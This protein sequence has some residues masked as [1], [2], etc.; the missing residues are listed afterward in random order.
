M[1]SLYADDARRDFD[2]LFAA[3][4]A[5]YRETPFWAWNSALEPAELLRQIDIFRKMGM[6]GFHM[7][8]R[9]GLETPYLSEEFMARV[10]ECVEGA[11]ER[12]MLAWLY[13]EDRWPSGAAGGIVTKDPRYRARFLRLTPT[14]RSGE[15]PH[16]V[17]AVKLDAADCLESSRILAADETLKDGETRFFLYRELQEESSWFNGETYLDT[18]NPEAVQKFIDVTYEAYFRSVGDEFGKVIPAIFTDEPQFPA[19]TWLRS[20]RSGEDVILPWTDTFDESYRRCYGTEF[21]PTIPE[22]VWQL[23]GD[24]YST[25]RYRYH[26]HLAERFAGAFCDEIGQWCEAHGIRFSGHLNAEGALTSQTFCIGEAM[27]CYRSFQLPGID[28][29]C[30]WFEYSTA[31]Q[32]ASVSR[33]A[34]RG[35]VL[36]ELDGVTDWDF[37]FMGH[38][39]H[40]DWQAALGVTV[41][42]PHL[43]W[44]SMAGEA[45]RDYPASI[46]YQSPWFEKYHLIADHF[47]RVNCAMSRG[48]ARVRVGVIHPIESFWLHC[49]PIEQTAG[50]RQQSEEDFQNLIQWL[51]FGLIDFDFI[52][53][54][55]LP[56][57][58]PLQIGKCLIVGEMAYDVV[59][60]PP[61]VTL[62][63]S[64]LERLEQFVAAG[65]RV[66]FSGPV[67]TLADAIESD[68]AAK[69]AEK[70]EKVPFNRIDLLEALAPER[71]VAVICEDG[72]PSSTLIYQLRRENDKGYLFLVNTARMGVSFRGTVRIRGSWQS[73]LLNT[74]DGTSTPLAGRIENDWTLL[75]KQDFCAHGHLLLKL[76]PAQVCE[77]VTLRQV[78]F[79]ED[80]VEKATRGFLRMPEGTVPVSLD[81]PNVLLL[82]Q[83]EWKLSGDGTWRPRE[84][85]LRLNNLARAEMGL[86]P[87]TGHIVQPWVTKASDKI[88]DTLEMRF[89]IDSRVPVSGAR[90]ALEQPETTVVFWDGVEVPMNVESWWTDR[91]VKCVALPEFPAGKHELILRRPYSERTNVEWA[92]LLGD[93]GVRLRGDRAVIVE[94]VR[95]LTLGDATQQGLPFFGGNI[96]YHFEYDAPETRQLMLHLPSRASNVPEGLTGPNAAREVLF[97]AFRGTLMSVRLDGKEMGDLAF[98]PFE[99]ALG[100]VAAGRHAIDLTLY[101]SRINC[102]GAV[103]LSFR[104]SWMGPQAWRTNG[105]MFSYEYRLQPFGLF[106]APRLLDC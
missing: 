15:T 27:R 61:T 23:P 38:K 21:L 14:E 94:P 8:A 41:R 105:D 74:A 3:P 102:F 78:P 17:F 44:L 64:T 47:A 77:G 90:L 88:L 28:M 53:E 96:T 7:H 97:S 92:Y 99:C 62:R 91:A 81:E 60:V 50:R 22:I 18:L 29:L 40:G 20:A 9:T 45:K 76:E 12:K 46:S 2:A 71:D 58:S 85:V 39:G 6:G 69:L 83:A 67:A 55:L 31:K 57:Q 79:R 101:G 10:R 36:C 34:G 51:L 87:V 65:G 24:R 63:N 56:K 49:G 103:H 43:A 82:D 70:C 98:A 106:I 30:D 59:I 100:E 75:E 19:K 25:A 11:R 54:A 89:V 33:Q 1:E 52:S 37:S 68:R 86:P 5:L 72:T 66:I 80:E 16:A 95:E 13:D 35:G 84:E 4:G 42:V 73:S 32:V 48:R 93:F 26:D 104:Y